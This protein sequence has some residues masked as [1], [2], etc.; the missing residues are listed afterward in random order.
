M[1]SLK[2]LKEFEEYGLMNVEELNVEG[3]DLHRA[4]KKN[5]ADISVVL[6]ARKDDVNASNTDDGGRRPL[7]IAAEHN[8]IEVVLSE[9]S[10][11]AE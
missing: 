5:R 8:S 3:W 1:R 6:I 10:V 9:L 4:A 11:G 2:C 7:H